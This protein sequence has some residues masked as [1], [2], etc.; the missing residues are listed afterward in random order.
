MLTLM[1]LPRKI[2]DIDALVVFP[3]MGENERLIE[4]IN[5]WRP[6]MASKKLFITGDEWKVNAT[7][8][9]PIFKNLKKSPFNLPITPMESTIYFQDHAQNTKD[10]ADW[11]CKLIYGLKV[12]SVALFTAP[13]HMPRSFMTMIK[14]LET[15]GGEYIPILPMPI[16]LAPHEISDLDNNDTPNLVQKEILKIQNYQEK[17][18]VA[19][20]KETDKYLQWLWKQPLIKH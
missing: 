13:Y 4:T 10:Q 9:R 3:G 5:M 11:A 8:V 15:F 12:K 20:L 17:G 2:A 6:H 14:S 19:T 1:A 18:D 16:N 7:F